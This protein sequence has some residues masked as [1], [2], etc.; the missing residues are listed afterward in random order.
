MNYEA[1][2]FKLCNTL[3][4]AAR[5]GAYAAHCPPAKYFLAAGQAI[6]AVLKKYDLKPAREVLFCKDGKGGRVEAAI[7]IPV[8]DERTLDMLDEEARSLAFD[9][10]VEELGMEGEV[11]VFFA[12]DTDWAEQIYAP[13]SLNMYM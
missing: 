4:K 9:A 6:A 10:F 3:R 13:G 8:M 2:A 5:E 12:P 1:Y 7:I 11:Q